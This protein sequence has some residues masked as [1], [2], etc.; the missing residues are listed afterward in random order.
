MDS[1]SFFRTLYDQLNTEEEW[2][3]DVL[4]EKRFLNATADY[5]RHHIRDKPFD[6][7]IYGGMRFPSE[8]GKDIVRLVNSADMQRLRD[9]KQLS[10]AQYRFPSATHSRFS[11]SLGVAYLVSSAAKTLGQNYELGQG[12]V[13]DI[14][15]A[16]LV[17]DS[18]HGPLGHVLDKLATRRGEKHMHEELTVKVVREGLLDMSDAISDVFCNKNEVIQIL[19]SI[20]PN[21]SPKG[22]KDNLWCSRLVGNYGMDFDRVDFILRDLYFIGYPDVVVR[23]SSIDSNLDFSSFSESNRRK[24]MVKC[25]TS[26]VCQVELPDGLDL[27]FRNKTEVQE[28]LKDLCSL[29]VT[30]YSEVYFSEPVFTAEWMV[31]KALELAILVSEFDAK[32]LYKY[33][34]SGLGWA[35]ETCESR[36]VRQIAW[37]VKHRRLFTKAYEFTPVDGVSET[38]IEQAVSEQFNLKESNGISDVVIA[39]T[40]PLRKPLPLYV[41]DDAGGYH[42][43]PLSRYLDHLNEKRRTCILAPPDSPVGKDINRLQRGI[44]DVI[45]EP[46]RPTMQPGQSILEDYVPPD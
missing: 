42:Q 38:E 32:S 3:I 41:V 20:C 21:G 8:I 11:H 16:A 39:A 34:D 18:G 25:L 45:R 28:C 22:G 26:N 24:E 40:A 29:Y 13:K 43:Y 9:V 12:F 33:T 14:T 19:E 10:F 36:L 15:I 27:G 17:H 2:P 30:L 46:F 4:L 44:R 1:F 37:A 35:L 31:A 6:D 5:L 7:P 23:P